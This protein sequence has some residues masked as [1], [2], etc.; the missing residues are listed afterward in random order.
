MTAL[1]QRF[2]GLLLVWLAFVAGQAQALTYLAPADLDLT[3]LLAPPPAPTSAA[4]ATDLAA[5]LGAQESRTAPDAEVAIAD[6]QVSVF[7]FAD[8]LGPAF[9]ED[10]LPLTTAI[11][12]EVGR[13]VVAAGRLAKQHWHRPRPF[14][15]SSQIKPLLP[16]S[17]DGSYPSGHAM[18]GYVTALLLAW[19]VP[20]QRA[21]LIARGVRY[22]E[23]RVTAG[24]H[25]PTDIVAG[26]TA[27]TAM[28]AVL[29]QKPR[30]RADLEASR[31]EIRSALELP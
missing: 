16:V 12:R 29:L 2:P 24:M 3:V 8:V 10:N 7:R 15:A 14:V 31:Q 30:F 25:Y 26:R 20:E 19:Q 1:H 23:N 4:Q 11:F 28:A 22:G 17:S 9:T 6:A 27:A 13:E 5:V 21:A 18:F